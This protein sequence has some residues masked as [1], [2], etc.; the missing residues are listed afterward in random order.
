MADSKE[1]VKV[2]VAALQDKKAEDIRI[3]DIKFRIHCWI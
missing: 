1:M 3:I 2:M